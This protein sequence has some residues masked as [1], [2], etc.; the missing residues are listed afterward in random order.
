[1]HFTLKVD[2]EFR[3]YYFLKAILTANIQSH[4]TG[5]VLFLI[6]FI[7]EVIKNGQVRTVKNSSCTINSGCSSSSSSSTAT[8]AA[9]E[10]AAS[11]KAASTTRVVSTTG[12]FKECEK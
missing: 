2:N 8:E 9:A 11:V 7:T 10:T 12:S 4:T 3:K 5:G 1:L 6:R